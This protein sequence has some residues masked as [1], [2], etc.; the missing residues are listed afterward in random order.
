MYKVQAHIV[1]WKSGGENRGDYEEKIARLMLKI[2]GIHCVPFLRKCFAV[3][4]W[5]KGE[6]QHLEQS[7]LMHNYIV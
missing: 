7:A 4:T 6:G 5:R 1:I 2:L 3:Q